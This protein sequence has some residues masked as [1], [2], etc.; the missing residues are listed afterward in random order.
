[1]NLPVLLK[2]ISESI[3]GEERGGDTT[4]SSHPCHTGCAATACSAV[5]NDATVSTVAAG[6]C[7]CDPTRKS[8]ATG[9]ARHAEVPVLAEDTAIDCGNDNITQNT[10]GVFPF[11]RFKAL[12][13]VWIWDMVTFTTIALIGPAGAW[14]WMGWCKGHETGLVLERGSGLWGVVGTREKE[15]LKGG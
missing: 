9:E 10:A 3:G 6:G 13:R 1:M 12:N 4:G 15:E 2:S 14:C 5:R 8:R 7:T 11:S